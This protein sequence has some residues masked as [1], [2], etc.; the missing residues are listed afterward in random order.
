MVQIFPGVL[1]DMPFEVGSIV[2]GKVA[3]WALVRCLPGVNE[4][5]GL[6][7]DILTK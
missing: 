5:V 3:L 7:I 6:Q 4:G 2:A 1:L